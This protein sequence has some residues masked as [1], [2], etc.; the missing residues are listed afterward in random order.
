MSTATTTPA[1]RRD[2]RHG[3]RL[4][5]SVRRYF[6]VRDVTLTPGTIVHGAPAPAGTVVTGWPLCKPLCSR[7]QFRKAMKRLKRKHPNAYGVKIDS[8]PGERH[9]PARIQY[10]VQ[11]N[12]GAA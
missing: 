5:L 1:T 6:V 2:A 4:G 7:L 9:T 10:P 8:M 12:G 11:A 3:S